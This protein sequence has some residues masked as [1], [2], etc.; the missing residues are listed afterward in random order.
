MTRLAAP[1]AVLGFAWLLAGCGGTATAP[2]PAAQPTTSAEVTT[3]ALPPRVTHQE[4]VAKL[5]RLCRRGNA[6][7]KPFEKRIDAADAVG[8]YDGI[9]EAIADAMKIDERYD[10]A[11]EALDV[12]AE[13]ARA[14]RR[15]LDLSRSMDALRVRIIRA[16]RA[17]DDDEL[18]R[19]GEIVTTLQKRRTV[20]TAGMGL[21]ECG[22]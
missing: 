10:T 15:Y 5:D 9:A 13:D 16:L 11:I 1:I 3:T 2:T 14:F 19:L 12:P 22:S 8:D 18:M 17:R 4:F 7:Y 6:A 20:V 21:T